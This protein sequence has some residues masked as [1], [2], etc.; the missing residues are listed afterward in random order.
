MICNGCD[1]FMSKSF[2]PLHANMA[3][4]WSDNDAEKLSEI[5]MMQEKYAKLLL[6]EDM[7]GGGK[8]VSSALAISNAITNL[9]ASVFGEIWKLEPLSQK[10]KAM[11][12]R[13]IDWLVSIADHIID[14]V[15]S[16]QTFADG[17]S[18]EIM[19]SR[20]RRD[21]QLNLPALRKLDTMLLECLDNFS[22]VEFWYVERGSIENDT[23]NND[24]RTPLHRHEDK[25][26]LPSVKVPSNGISEHERKRLQNQRD[27]ISQVLKAAMAINSQILS[28][29]EVPDVY[30]KTLPKNGK[31][32]LGEMM[33]KNITSDS[34]TPE[35][36]LGVCDLSSEHKIVELA[37]QIEAAIHVWRRSQPS[38]DSS[39]SSRDPKKASKS[40]WDIVKEFVSDAERRDFL[41]ERAEEVLIRLRQKFPGLRQSL[42][43][44]TKIQHNKDV[45][46]SILESYSRVMES[47]ASSILSRIDD[48][49]FAD[50]MTKHALALSHR[51]LQRSITSS[52]KRVYSMNYSAFSS[53]YGTGPRKTPNTSPI[54]SPRQR[55]TTNS[56]LKSDQNQVLS[57]YICFSYE[58]DYISAHS[59]IHGSKKQSVGHQNK[60]ILSSRSMNS[61]RSQSVHPVQDELHPN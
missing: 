5:E 28:E 34:F 7:S 59:G 19:V 30:W 53:S 31:A 27:C 3:S 14:L 48:V 6:G 47:L 8:G 40:S 26:W 51:P 2:K 44:M 57:D 25:W 20:P 21:L 36:F 56:P 18:V 61:I 12:K 9:S 50:D 24:L 43:D 54:V 13:E 16:I 58:V 15:P 52:Q 60:G 32:S 39:K 42:L 1:Q 55:K 10:R 11:W 41:A 33:H 45:G 29:M 4:V 46:Q 23:R 38:K 37:D 49:I 22:E 17:S 35:A